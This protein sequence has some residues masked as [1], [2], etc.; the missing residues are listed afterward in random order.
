MRKHNLQKH[1]MDELKEI[2]D[3]VEK[4]GY[5]N[6]IFFG[7]KEDDTADAFFDGDPQSIEEMFVTALI[8]FHDQYRIPME[9]I[10]GKIHYDT[11]Y[12]NSMLERRSGKKSLFDI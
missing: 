9:D 10:L 12:A 3:K 8:A 7:V 11:A 5:E 1:K 6:A 4:A 2:H